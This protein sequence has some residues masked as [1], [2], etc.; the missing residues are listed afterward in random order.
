MVEVGRGRSTPSRGDNEGQV[1]GQ[2][3]KEKTMS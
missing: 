1:V 2:E 3:G